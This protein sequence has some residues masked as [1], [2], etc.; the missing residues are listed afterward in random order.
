GLAGSAVPESRPASARWTSA[1]GE[2]APL[3]AQEPD[4]ARDL[5]RAVLVRACAER[6]AVAARAA[7]AR[8]GAA[9]AA[10]VA[11]SAVLVAGRRVGDGVAAITRGIAA[12]GRCV[13]V[14]AVRGVMAAVA[15]LRAMA[16]EAVAE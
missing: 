8:S 10:G 6:P 1:A 4:A 7:V 15:A 12:A 9:L 3:Q 2:A 5:Q 11:R 13:V 14:A 16:G